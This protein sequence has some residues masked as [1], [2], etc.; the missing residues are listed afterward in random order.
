MIR[1]ESP[2]KEIESWEGRDVV[3]TLSIPG[4]GVKM[5]RVLLTAIT[6]PFILCR[7]VHQRDQVYCVHQVIGWEPYDSQGAQVLQS[8]EESEAQQVAPPSTP[9]KDPG[10]REVAKVRKVIQQG[11]HGSLVKMDK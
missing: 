8:Q 2:I 7:D 9:K 5:E 3:L 4:V 6:G 10:I 1:S 11:G